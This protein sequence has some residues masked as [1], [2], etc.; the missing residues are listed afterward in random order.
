MS[1]P[2]GSETDIV[3]P[4]LAGS[5]ALTIPEARF[6]EMTL[7]L[8]PT[9]KSVRPDGMAVIGGDTPR[10][11]ALRQRIVEQVTA[12]EF[13]PL[14]EGL[15][16]LIAATLGWVGHSSGRWRPERL[17]V[18][19]ARRRVAKLAQEYIE[20]HYRGTV[21]IEDLCRAT[22]VG[23]RTLQ[24]CFCEYFDLTTTEYLKAVRLDR[25]RRALVAAHAS[26][27]SVTAVALQH[28]IAHLGRFSVEF[29]ERFRESPRETLAVRASRMSEITRTSTS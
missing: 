22:G 2:P 3:V 12:P 24:R 19:G 18:N 27:D 9:P 11:N 7:A 10:L 8:Y 20:A 29:R 16:N 26:H 1:S 21:R 14:Q 13:D 15:S 23:V 28:G 5:D 17:V 6:I 25:V 4:D